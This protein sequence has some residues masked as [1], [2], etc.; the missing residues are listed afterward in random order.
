PGFARFPVVLHG[1][2]ALALRRVPV[3]HLPH[4]ARLAE[5]RCHRVHRDPTGRLLDCHHRWRCAIRSV[6]R[7]R[8][9]I[10]P[11]PVEWRSGIAKAGL[12]HAFIMALLED[13]DGRLWVGTR[14]GLARIEAERPPGRPLRTHVYAIKDGLPALRIESL[15]QSS[16]GTLW[17]GTDEGLAEWN[18]AQPPGGSEFQSYTVS[19]GLSARRVGAMAE[20]RDGNLWI[21]TDG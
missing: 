20:D 8:F 11:L 21:G 18:P 5:Q 15:F 12:P 2:R 4:R 7:R 14:F 19:Q 1:G 10:S 13:R 17:V 9:Q 3:H 6:R 16:D